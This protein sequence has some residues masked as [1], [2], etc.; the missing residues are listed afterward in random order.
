MLRGVQVLDLSRVLAGPWATQMLADLGATV[1]KVERAKL[2]D[3]TRHWGP[4]YNAQGLA[5][6]FTCANRGKESVSVDF[7]NQEQLMAVQELALNADVVVENFKVGQLKAFGLDATSLRAKKPSLIYCSI[8]G[9]GQNGPRAHE[10]G[11]DFALQGL[12]GLMSITGPA[13]GP[14]YK[15]GVAVIDIITGIYACNAITASLFHRTQTGEG[16]TIDCALFDTG[17]AL[18]ANQGAAHLVAGAEPKAMGNTHPSIVP[19]QA[20]HAKDGYLVLAVGNDRQFASL[21]KALNQSHWA[22]DPRFITNPE[23]VKNRDLLNGMLEPLLKTENRSH[24]LEQFEAVG[25]PCTPVQTISEVFKEPQLH[26]RAM[27][28][29]HKQ[30]VS[31]ANEDSQ[32]TKPENILQTVGQPMVINGLRP[33]HPLAPPSLG[34]TVRNHPKSQRE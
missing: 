23:R 18:L 8:T 10:A 16:A 24:W 2:G 15:V 14:P 1:I 12:T 6:Y 33:S 34:P 26:E 17:V 25:V 19:Y 31:V 27:I 11:Y 28:V 29:T 9:Y 22:E 32:S 30:K 7:K 20:Y 5:T 13:N 21:A 3:D 4:P